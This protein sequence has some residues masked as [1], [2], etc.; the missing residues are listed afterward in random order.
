MKNYL[1]VP[2]D[3][4]AA[5]REATEKLIAFFKRGSKGSIGRIYPESFTHITDPMRKLTHTK[6]PTATDF[7]EPDPASGD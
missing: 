5:L 3:D 7:A 2:P 6:Y 1:L 4:I